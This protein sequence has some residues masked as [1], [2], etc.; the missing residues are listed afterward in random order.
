MKKEYESPKAEKLE[1]AYSEVITTSGT[2]GSTRCLIGSSTVSW[3]DS[4]NYCSSTVPGD[5]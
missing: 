3:A 2:K 1:F 4:G 5:E